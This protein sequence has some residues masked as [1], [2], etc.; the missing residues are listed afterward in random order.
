MTLFGNKVF[1]DVISSDNVI[2]VRGS[3]KSN[4]WCHYRRPCED[5][6]TCI[7]EG[8]EH[9]KIETETEVMFH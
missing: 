6:E 5:T 1:V 8:E 7:G 2:L 4:D 3:L 9:V